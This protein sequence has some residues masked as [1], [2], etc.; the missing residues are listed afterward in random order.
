MKRLLSLLLWRGTGAVL[1]DDR[2]GGWRV[3]HT[4][5]IGIRAALCL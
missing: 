3:H 4:Y 2:T 1:R 5:G